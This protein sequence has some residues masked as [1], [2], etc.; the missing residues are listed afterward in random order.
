MAILSPQHPLLHLL[1]SLSQA[2]YEFRIRDWIVLLFAASAAVAYL[3][4]GIIW[5]KSDPNAYLMYTSPQA[6]SDF[7]V[8]PKKTRN[9]VQKLEETVR[10][11]LSI[12]LHNF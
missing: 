4:D 5:G 12:P 7:K 9:I 1:E 10:A 2:P 6:S 3:G 8:K 11:S